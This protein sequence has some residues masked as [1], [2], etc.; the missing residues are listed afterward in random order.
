MTKD[1][2]DEREGVQSQPVHKQVYMNPSSFVSHFDPPLSM[3]MTTAGPCDDYPATSGG[4][5][6]SM[7][8]TEEGEVCVRGPSEEMMTRMFSGATSSSNTYIPSNTWEGPC[9]GYYFG[10]RDRKTG[11]HRDTAQSDAV[12][13]VTS[14][15]LQKQTQE[16]NT[17][18]DVREALEH[19]KSVYSDGWISCPETAPSY[20]AMMLIFQYNAKRL[21]FSATK[22]EHI[23]WAR[24]SLPD[25]FA[26]IPEIKQGKHDLKFGETMIAWLEEDIETKPYTNISKGTTLFLHDVAMHVYDEDACV[27]RM[28]LI[29]EDSISFAQSHDG[30]VEYIKEEKELARKYNPSQDDIPSQDNVP[31]Q[32]DVPSQEDV[33][34]Q[35]DVHSLD[36]DASQE[37][38][39][40]LDN[41]KDSTSVRSSDN[42]SSSD[43]PDS[44][45]DHR[46]CDINK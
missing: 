26:I 44:I 1:S 11:Y 8:I 19:A 37:D 14:I 34:S 6:A 46:Q 15:G 18:P 23:M 45:W 25:H 42:K 7:N 9:P 38:E 4:H 5:A 36:D 40:L 10:T 2:D 21:S 43:A 24:K 31:S 28:L 30:G 39:N 17:Q 13:S 29:G 20:K 35:N 33:P 3:M 41:N 32:D 22:E 27:N 12:G 16:E